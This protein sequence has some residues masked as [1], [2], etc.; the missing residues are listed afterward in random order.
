MLNDAQIAEA[1]EV[2]KDTPLAKTWTELKTDYLLRLERI[3]AQP[4]AAIVRRGDPPGDFYIV[5]VGNARGRLYRQGRPWFEWELKAGHCFGQAALYFNLPQIEVVAV[6]P[7]VFYRLRPFD[8][9]SALERNDKLYEFLLH[10]ELAGRLRRLPVLRSV[11]NATI[12]QLAALVEVVDLDAERDVDLSQAG[13]L[14]V[15]E[16]GQVAVTGP[17]AFELPEWRLTA[18]N[19]FMAPEATT[20]V[21]QT[22]TALTART[23]YA[24]RLVRFLAGLFNALADTFPDVA[25]LTRRPLNLRDWLPYNGV[26]QDLSREQRMHLAQF[27]GWMFVPA[28]QNITTQGQPGYGLVILR[29]G[30][31]VRAAVDPQ[32]RQRPRDMLYAPAV[33]GETSLFEGKEH[34]VTVRAVSSPAMAAHGRLDGADIIVLDRRDLNVAFLEN[35]Q[36]WT[37]DTPLKQRTVQV[38]QEAR[39]FEWM[40]DGEKL[41]W[42]GRP[43]WLWLAGPLAAIGLI[44]L[45]L[46]A[47]TLLAPAEIGDELSVFSLIV[48]ALVLLPAAAFALGN[49]LDD[50]YVITNRRVTRRDRLLLLYEARTETPLDMIQDVTYNATFW[51]R[52]FDYGDV[53]I[54]SAARAGAIKFAHVPHPDQVQARIKRGQAET[55]AGTRG[56][57]HEELRKAVMTDLRLTLPIPP[58]GRALSAD[59]HAPPQRHRWWQLRRR[60]RSGRKL[61]ALRGTLPGPFVRLA[62]RLPDRWRKLLIGGPAQEL[63]VGEGEFLWRK[64]P[65]Q[66]IFQA[67]RPLI[68]LLIWLVFGWILFRTELGAN[69]IAL[70][71]PWWFFFCFFLGWLLWEFADYRNDLYILKEDRI[72]D[73][74]ATPLW[75][76]IKRRE[77]SLDRVEN[78]FAEQKGVWQNLLGYG[79]VIIKTA[80]QDEGFTFKNVANPQYVQHLIFQ[81]LD[82]FKLRQNERQIRDR[83]REII[84]GLSVY[85]ELR[86][87]GHNL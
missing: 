61:P 53:T 79:D 22:C 46:W 7:T 34:E 49:Y 75:L 55:T 15:I 28:G 18:G 39:S 81:K 68:L 87:E 72:I 10:P 78:V 3:E 85:H 8:L 38:K 84:E 30:A 60:Q 31:A 27:C 50:Y 56:L 64:H 4:G 11:D 33:Y 45:A 6:E 47:I 19:F 65:I 17:A 26:F 86:S 69:R 24:S 35:P 58:V 29:Q 37:A 74:E 20:W 44:F 83:Q 36:L 63:Q 70:H 14:Y 12:L 40:Q 80:A 54:R 32:G 23:C 76:S 21:G 1:W 82:A 5:G 43:H 42:R 25:Q 73:I 52:V 48:S 51:G 77:G 41:E 59:T 62:N 71:L 9:R 67:G 2:L 16:W 66:L 57:R 13:S